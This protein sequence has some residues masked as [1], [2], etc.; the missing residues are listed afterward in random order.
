LADENVGAR[1]RGINS[2]DASVPGRRSFA[3]RRDACQYRQSS[4][5]PEGCTATE[6]SRKAARSNKR[7]YPRAF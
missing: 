5:N 2:M 3:R 4:C 1:R 7:N 6:E